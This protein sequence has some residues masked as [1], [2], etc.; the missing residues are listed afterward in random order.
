M[1]IL[2]SYRAE[3]VVGLLNFFRFSTRAMNATSQGLI[4]DNINR[5]YSRLGYFRSL[6]LTDLKQL[7]SM[8]YEEYSNTL[9]PSPYVTHC[10]YYASSDPSIKHGDDD[11]ID[12][13]TCFES[14]VENRTKDI[15]GVTL[16][17]VFVF[18]ETVK[19]H[20]N[21]DHMTV[22]E[23]YSNG[24]MLQLKNNLS[25]ECDELCSS[26]TCSDTFYI[27]ILQ[28]S[29]DYD[30]PAVITYIM[31]SPKI[32]TTCDPKLNLIGYFTNVFSTFGFWIGLSVFSVVDIAADFISERVKS[33]NGKRSYIDS[34]IADSNMSSREYDKKYS[35]SRYRIVHQS[36]RIRRCNCNRCTIDPSSNHIR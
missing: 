11:I 27:P 16:P 21:M 26:P 22:V 9:L 15:L 13:G 19:K 34:N 3:T 6:F 4:A 18:E 29:I 23:L 14:C 30:A 25:N 36:N 24:S 10:R 8:T 33:W 7:I 12:R 20:P 31:Q 5:K 28:S 17:G 2:K 35:L 32:D 1:A